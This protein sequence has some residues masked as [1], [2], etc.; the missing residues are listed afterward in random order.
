MDAYLNGPTLTKMVRGLFRQKLRGFL[1]KKSAEILENSAHFLRGTFWTKSA[2]FS[3]KKSAEF[4]VNSAYLRSK[5][6]LHG[7]NVFQNLRGAKTLW[8]FAKKVH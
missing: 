5:S 2:E 7:Y 4:K 8:T 6:R 1:P 3:E